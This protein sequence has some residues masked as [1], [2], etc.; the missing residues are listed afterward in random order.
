MRYPDPE[1]S[2][3]KNEAF[4]GGPLYTPSTKADVGEHDEDINEEQAEGIVG[5][6]YADRVEEL[7]IE[8]YSYAHAYALELEL[9]LADTK[10]E[11]GLDEATDEIVLSGEISTPESS[12][13]WKG[14]E[15]CVGEAVL[16]VDKQ[17]LRDCIGT[18][19]DRIVDGQAIKE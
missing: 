13:A 7:T 1:G 19:Q 10:F 2:Y 14:E 11:F 15:Y 6:K 8:I 3:G 17:Y 18:L 9:I 12:R 16:G 4:P 5:A